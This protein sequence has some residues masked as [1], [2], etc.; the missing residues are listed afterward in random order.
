MIEPTGVAADAATILFNLPDYHVISTSVTAGRRRVVI[1]TDQPPGCP[2]CGVI[3]SRRKE[4]R[5]QRLRDI[6]VAGPVDVLWSKYRW[7]CQEPACDRLSFFESTPQVP[8]HARSTSRLRDQLV[9]AVIRSGRAVSETAAGFAVS[10]WMVRAAVTEACLLRLPDVDSLSPRLLG[11]DEHRFRSVRYFQDPSTKAW[12]RFEPWMTTIVNL[13][14]GQVLGVVDGRDHKGVG[15][16]LFARPLEWRPAVQ[17]VAIDPSAAFRKALRM[18]LPRTAVAVDH[19]HLSWLANQAMTETRQNLSQQVKGRCGRAMDKAWA[20]RM[21]LL[22]G[23]D[24]LSCRA[25]LRL[26]EVFAADDSTG[27]LQAVWKVKEQL[28][29][30][31]R[32]GSLKDAATAKKVLEDLVKAAARPETNRLYRTVC[33]WCKEIEVL[34]ITGA[35]TAKVE[36]NNTA[37][38]RI[39]R[40]AR[41]YR[42]PDNYKSVILLRSA[43]RTAA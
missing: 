19:F 35:T 33:R 28:R 39:K 3:A 8:R 17:V 7:Y 2:S 12:T 30:L 29:A 18:W 41:G 13:D 15:D 16:W 6:P 26:E 42:N 9:D 20:H 43:V 21:L 10:W 23:S 22:G 1:E 11:I 36:A 37:I 34:I 25:A 24:T 4:R 14:T 31:L 38:K 27:T 5:L 40:T 32:M